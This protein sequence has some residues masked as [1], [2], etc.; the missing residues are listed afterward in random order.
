M[1]VHRMSHLGSE[2]VTHSHKKHISECKA[3]QGIDNGNKGG[4]RVQ[5]GEVGSSP[6]AEE[7]HKH[8]HHFA[9]HQGDCS[10]L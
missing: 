4:H 8:F 2:P 10:S 7:D 1:F 3:H 5:P 9:A 6:E